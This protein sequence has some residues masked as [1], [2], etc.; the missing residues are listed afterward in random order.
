M[1][2]AGDTIL[3]AAYSETGAADRIVLVN[4]D[5]FQC[6]DKKSWMKLS[7]E[8]NRG[9]Q[10]KGDLAECLLSAVVNASDSFAHL[11]SLSI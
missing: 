3:L 5:K 9:V 2:F 11:F 8:G 7:L 10:S 4:Y 6:F 1:Q